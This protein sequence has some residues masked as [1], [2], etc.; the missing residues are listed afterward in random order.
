MYREPLTIG[1]FKLRVMTVV[2]STKQRVSHAIRVLLPSTPEPRVPGATSFLRVR[3]PK[4]VSG[5]HTGTGSAAALSELVPGF[6]VVAVIRS[7]GTERRSG[8]A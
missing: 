1:T 7:K 8:G 5:F 6:A 2:L 3:V 4:L